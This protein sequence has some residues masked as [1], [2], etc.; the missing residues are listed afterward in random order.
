M[1]TKYLLDFIDDPALRQNVQK[2][3]NRG[4]SYHRMRRAISYVNSGKFRVKTGA[5]QQIWNECSRLIANAIIFY[6]T[7]LLSRVYEQK[8]AAGDL[9]ASRASRAL[10]SATSTSSATSTLQ[11]DH[12]RSTSKPSRPAIRTKTFGDAPC[13][14]QRTRAR[15]CEDRQFYLFEALGKNSH[16]AAL[17]CFSRI[18]SWATLRRPLSH[19]GT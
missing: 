8:V 11:P 16:E 17:G 18:C 5:E 4:E 6:N 1:C 14:K 12:R 7:L 2:A 15:L 9:D 13:P 10:P 3:L 19:A